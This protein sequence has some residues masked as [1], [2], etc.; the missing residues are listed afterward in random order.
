MRRSIAGSVVFGLNLNSSSSSPVQ[1]RGIPLQQLC[2]ISRTEA[3]NMYGCITRRQ[4]RLA[5]RSAPSGT[6]YHNRRGRGRCGGGAN[7]PEVDQTAAIR[8]YTRASARRGDLGRDY[9][10]SVLSFLTPCRSRCV[11]SVSSAAAGCPGTRARTRAIN[12]LDRFHQIA[13]SRIF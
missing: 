11:V 2:Q 8:G 1:G 10:L 9:K 13:I 7:G 12:W 5:G 3:S 4:S 6:Q